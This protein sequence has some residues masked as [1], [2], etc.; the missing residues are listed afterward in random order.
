MKPEERLTEA[1]QLY[2][3]IVIAAGVVA[4]LHSLSRSI[5]LP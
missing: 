1:A 3:G 4:V 2:V 5:S